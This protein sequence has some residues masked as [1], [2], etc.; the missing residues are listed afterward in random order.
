MLE[1]ASSASSAAFAVGCE[2]ASRFTCDHARLFQAPPKRDTL[3]L[4]RHPAR[5]S[6]R[7]RRGLTRANQCAKRGQ[8]PGPSNSQGQMRFQTDPAP[9]SR[10]ARD[11]PRFKTIGRPRHTA[12]LCSHS[13]RFNLLT[14]QSIVSR[15]FQLCNQPRQVGGMIDGRRRSLAQGGCSAFLEVWQV[16]SR[17]D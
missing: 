6:G 8:S 1:E 10:D 3:R 4:R 14:V 15:L 16:S 2:S 5:W 13:G 12:P 7:R 11:R 9:V 17:S